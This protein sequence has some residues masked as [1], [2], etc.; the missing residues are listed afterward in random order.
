MVLSQAPVAKPVKTER[1][2]R[3]LAYESA[4]G[5]EE[6]DA[7]PEAKSDDTPE[8]PPLPG[9]AEA[10]PET[11]P[12]PTPKPKQAAKPPAELP[13]D[14]SDQPNETAALPPA[15]DGT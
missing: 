8:P 10:K 6:A 9:E 15:E 14:D 2:S 7:K 13:P 12:P 4:I 1:A 3:P 5:G 11:P